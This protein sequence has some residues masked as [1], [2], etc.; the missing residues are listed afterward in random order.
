MALDSADL[1]QYARDAASRGDDLYALLSVDATTPKE[2]IH[3]AWR[4]AGLKYHPD[5]AGAN[6]D[7]AKYESFERARD[8]L[9]DPA[10]REAYDNGLKAVLQ[11]RKRVEEMSGERRRF[12]EELERA[13][14]EAKRA[15]TGERETAGLSLAERQRAAEAG[16]RRMEERA[17]L[18]REAEERSKMR[19]KSRETSQEASAPATPTA[20]VPPGRPIPDVTAT[21]GMTGTN[22]TPAD[23]ASSTNGDEYE[24]KIAELERKLKEKRERKAAKK[25]S[26]KSDVSGLSTGWSPSVEGD[27]IKPPDG[28]KA[29]SK[30]DGEKGT[31]DRAQPAKSATSSFAFRPPYAASAPTSPAVGK[32]TSSGSGSMPS[33]ASTMAR[34]KA[35]Q[36]KR[37]EEKRKREAEAA[38]AGSAPAGEQQA[39]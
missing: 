14:R 36:M 1:V 19:E 28:E 3:R 25:A 5:K 38:A 12:V 10:A 18:M 23:D 24:A 17:R 22:G 33:F 8:V 37:D 20:A 7:A 26:R 29:E 6:Y 32:Q 30:A 27:P 35:A 15:K 4:R 16:R 31:H 9:V 21:D 34:L 11:K 13:E 39:V 2:D